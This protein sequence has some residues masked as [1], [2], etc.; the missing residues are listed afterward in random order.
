MGTNWHSG[1]FDVLD[2]AF[3][4]EDKMSYVTSKAFPVVSFFTRLKKFM[5]EVG[6]QGRIMMLKTG[7]S[8][9]CIM[10]QIRLYKESH[11]LGTK[12]KSKSLIFI[13]L[14]LFFNPF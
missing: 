4:K 13:A 12:A 11:I 6:S 8:D 2:L 9:L 14:S 7:I 1:L 3:L 5:L 10:Q